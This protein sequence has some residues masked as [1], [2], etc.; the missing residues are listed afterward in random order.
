MGSSEKCAE[1]RIPVQKI[2]KECGHKISTECNFTPSKEDCTEIVLKS[3][4]ECG[5]TIQFQCGKT[6][7][8]KDCCVRVEATSICKHESALDLLCKDQPWAYQT[9]CLQKCN[10]ILS[11][12]HKCSGQC[13]ECYGGYVIF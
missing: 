1:C 12:N 3:I 2:I 5:H 10:K 8:R 11:C 6:P 4:E 13:K 9:K 7:T